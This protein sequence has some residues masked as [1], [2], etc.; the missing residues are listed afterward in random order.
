MIAV[1]I[2]P[3]TKADQEKLGMA[4]GKLMQEDPTFRVHTDRTRARR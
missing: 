3:K 4:L 1:S 2:E